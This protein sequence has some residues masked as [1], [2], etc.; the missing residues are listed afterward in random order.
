M[1]GSEENSSPRSNL[2]EIGHFLGYL[3]PDA[4]LVAGIIFLNFLSSLA[5]LPLMYLPTVLTA[6]FDQWAGASAH[7]A[8]AGSQLSTMAI[9]HTVDALRAF[10]GDRG[11]LTAAA[12]VALL[13][14]LLLGPLQLIRSYWSGVVG[15]NLLLRVRRGLFENL[16][17]LSM[18][19][20]YE[21]GAGPFVQRIT[22]D[23]FIMHD[24]LVQT[25]PGTINLVVQIAVFLTA[26]IA[27]DSRLTVVCL[28]AY[29]MLLPVLY[30]FNRGIQTQAARL[31]ELHEDVTTQMI[32]SVGGF[33][34]I[35]AVGC[36]ERLAD[37]FRLQSAQLRQQSV[38]TILWSQ[39]GE[40][41]LNLVFGALTVVP[42]LLLVRRL[43]NL[44]QV[45]EAITY[46]GL[47]SGLLP[48]LAGLWGISVE[49]SSATPSLFSL[50]DFLGGA[51]A[52][53]V[54]LPNG[55]AFRSQPQLQRQVDSIRFESVSLQ[56]DARWLVRDLTFE[57]HGREVTAIIGQS[58]AGKTTIFNLLLRL[59]RP[60]SGVIWINDRRLDDFDEGDLRRL[61]G[62]IP[63]NPFIFNTSLRENILVAASGPQDLH[64]REI[65]E[66][67]QLTEL[68][69]ARASDGGLESAAGYLGMRL[70]GGERQRVALARLIVQDP[71][72]IVCDE[73]TA[74]IDVKT[75]QLIQEMM[76]TRFGDRTRLLVTHELWAAKDANR[77]LVLDQG[78][79]VQS[80][81]HHDL[82]SGLGLYRSMWEAQ[83]I[84]G[85]RCPV[86][87]HGAGLQVCD[88]GGE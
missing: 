85:A 10:F 43:E 47:L 72:I 50:H 34:D 49:L 14:I 45:G 88:A 31:K 66:A 62:F 20:V 44:A 51:R 63:Q 6:H 19:A 37:K 42:Y 65:I 39:Y 61:I 17:T 58:G 4:A 22:R 33:R 32:E 56:I 52:T 69:E 55:A 54:G 21:R 35:I 53:V 9:A 36:F 7:D 2:R 80:G 77:I 59:V 25:L 46:V 81:T 29:L 40:L 13:G 73:Y 83:R 82:V 24:L 71:Q 68:V 28:L 64:L 70:S 12:V 74:N 60:T 67:A 86:N 1:H 78:R 8:F 76:R 16:Q 79:I 15:G 30:R 38:Q 26:L 18:L 5:R 23:M 27:M 11:Y 87:Q 41:L 75:A 3:K 48:S 57:I 84:D